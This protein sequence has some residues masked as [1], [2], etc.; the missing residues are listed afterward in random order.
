MGRLK[1]VALFTHT[2]GCMGG[3]MEQKMPCCED[4]Q[5][6]LNVDELTFND[7]EFDSTPDWFEYYAFGYTDE[8]ETDTESTP[9]RFEYQSNAPPDDLII[10]HQVLII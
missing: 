2:E 7:F 6:R 1:N 4:T 9:T 3:D 10:V 8:I 5:E